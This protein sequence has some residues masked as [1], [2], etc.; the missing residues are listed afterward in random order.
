MNRWQALG[1]ALAVSAASVAVHA[2]DRTAVYARVDRVVLEPRSEA[3]ETIQIWGMFS[4][5]EPNNPN[6]YRPAARGYLYLRLGANKETALKEWADLQSV[7]ATDQIVAF[8]SR[9]EFKPRLRPAT[10]R[11]EGPDP[12]A[13]GIGLTKVSGKTDYAPVRALIGVRD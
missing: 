2:S 11:P 4:I 5:A 6:D 13:F 7:A 1:C 9:Y 12:Y 10:E 3:P 8:G